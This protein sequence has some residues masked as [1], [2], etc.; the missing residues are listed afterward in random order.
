[1]PNRIKELRTAKGWT[2]QD[3]AK[4][5]GVVKS[6]I[7]KVEAESKVPSTKLLVRIAAALECKLDDI[8]LD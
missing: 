6:T 2:Q 7:S 4:R 8:F 5:V 1:M 3:L